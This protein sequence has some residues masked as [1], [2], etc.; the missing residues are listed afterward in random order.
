MVYLTLWNITSDESF[1]C[2]A[3]SETDFMYSIKES[4]NKDSE[5]FFCNEKFTEDERGENWIKCFSCSV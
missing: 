3:L 1:H 5:C 2:D 4:E